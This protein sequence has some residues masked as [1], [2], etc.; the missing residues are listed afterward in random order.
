[1]GFV[2]GF[3]GWLLGLVSFASWLFLMY[4]AFT[5]KQ[6][7]IPVIGDVVWAQINK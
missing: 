4:S 1:V 3:A 5:G 2:F 7:K 6:F